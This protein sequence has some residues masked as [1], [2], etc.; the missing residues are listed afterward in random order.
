MIGLALLVAF[1]D[2]G[3]AGPKRVHFVTVSHHED[4]P[5]DPNLD[6][7][8]PL[9]EGS[10]LLQ[11]A[12]VVVC[13]RDSIPPGL[14][15]FR[16]D[17]CACCVEVTRNLAEVVRTYEH[18]LSGTIL[19]VPDEA[20][21]EPGVPAPQNTAHEIVTHPG[22]EDA[23]IYFADSIEVYEEDCDDDG[24]VWLRI[25]ANGFADTPRDRDPYMFVVFAEHQRDPAAH[26]RVLMHEFGHLQVGPGHPDIYRHLMAAGEN[27]GPLVELAL[28]KDLGFGEQWPVWFTGEDDNGCGLAPDR[29][30]FQGLP[31][32]PDG[33]VRPVAGEPD[34]EVDVDGCDGCDGDGGVDGGIAAALLLVGLRRCRSRAQ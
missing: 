29:D 18:P 32:L 28:C 9:R 15:C 33:S 11:R 34:D 23:L 27:G 6:V 31:D 2:I 25:E 26:P 8:T 4:V 12:D 7:D 10:A 21:G 16:E 24:C 17:D 30:E 14:S 22:N 1:L 3:N 19:I 20:A 5:F 13:D